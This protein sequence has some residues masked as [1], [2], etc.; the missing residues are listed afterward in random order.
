MTEVDTSSAKNVMFKKCPNCGFEWSSRR[1]F[2]DDPTLE[3]IGYQA[4]FEELAAGIFLFNHSCHGTLAIPSGRFEDL[5]QGP[6]FA[7]RAE[8]SEECPGYC[9]QEEELEPCPVECECAYVREIIQTIR[10]WPKGQAL[11]HS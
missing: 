3:I 2:L 8:D 6:I 4:N 7:R 9:L 10:H 5:Y 11:A 1:D